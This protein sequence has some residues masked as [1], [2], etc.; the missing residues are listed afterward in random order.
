VREDLIAAVIQDVSGID[1]RQDRTFFEAGLTSELV[2]AV[3]AALCREKGAE[4]P[5]SSFYEFPT[6]ATFA[7]FLSRPVERPSERPERIRDRRQLRA[8]IVDGGEI[9]PNSPG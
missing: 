5:I 7:A 1:V 2:L 8:W 6:L 9:W 3:H 4:F